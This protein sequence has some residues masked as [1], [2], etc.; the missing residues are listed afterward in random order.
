MCFSNLLAVFVIT[1]SCHLSFAGSKEVHIFDIRKNLQMKND[2]PVYHDYY[3]NAG[4]LDGLKPNVILTVV[5]RVPVHDTYSNESQD[6]LIVPV[7]R[8]KLLHVQKNISLGR[9]LEVKSQGLGPV[10]DYQAIMLGDRIPL[11][12]ASIDEG[13][14][15]GKEQGQSASSEKTEKKS[16]LMAEAQEKVEIGAGEVSLGIADPLGETKEV[17]ATRE[18]KSL[19][20]AVKLQ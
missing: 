13:R 7:G 11:S 15:E 20:P 12:S 5:R 17:S 14:E 18:P 3:I 19:K 4:A 2:D 9:R 6:D 10:L 1:I 16:E 8:I